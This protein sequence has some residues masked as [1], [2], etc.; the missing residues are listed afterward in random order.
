[1]PERDGRALYEKLTLDGF[2][3]G[4]SWITILRKRSGFRAAFAGFDPARVA[5]FEEADV[6]RLMADAGIVRNRRK[7]DATIVNAQ[8]LLRLQEAEGQGSLDALVWSFAPGRRRRPRGFDEVHAVTPE[9]TALSKELKR[10]GFAFVGPT[11]MY[12]AMQACGLV[13]DHV[14]G[15]HLAGERR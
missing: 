9:S 11:T 5:R 1:V 15:C 10:R 4:L 6:Q 12:A 13:D 3:A 14:A 8:A 7:I 2:Q